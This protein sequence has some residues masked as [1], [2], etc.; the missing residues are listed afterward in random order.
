MKDAKRRSSPHRKWQEPVCDLVWLRRSDLFCKL[1]S[2]A[3]P[4]DWT[5]LAAWRKAQRW[6]T[7]GLLNVLAT[8]DGRG[9]TYADGKWQMVVSKTEAA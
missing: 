5:Q 7:E 2:G 9:V 3:G 1:L 6:P 8:V 4:Q